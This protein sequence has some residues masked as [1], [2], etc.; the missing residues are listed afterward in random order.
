MNKQKVLYFYIW[1]FQM[2]RM[3]QYDL[4]FQRNF[5]F[6]G[7]GT[8]YDMLV[9]YRQIHMVV[10]KHPQWLWQDQAHTWAGSQIVIIMQLTPFPL[11]FFV[12]N[13]LQWSW[14]LLF[15][16]LHIPCFQFHRHQLGPLLS[17]GY[18]SLCPEVLLSM[19]DGTIMPDTSFIRKNLQQNGIF[20][21][22]LI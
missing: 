7:D 4:V 6:S 13:T 10:V 19:R 16:D 3:Q 14:A 21:F 2:N 18:S 11:I 17:P 15:H 5:L 20:L 22:H 9:L 8:T 12:T 1:C